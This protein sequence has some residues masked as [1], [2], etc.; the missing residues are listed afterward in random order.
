M[1]PGQSSP[2]SEK[3]RNGNLEWMTSNLHPGSEVWH[4]TPTSYSPSSSQLDFGECLGLSTAP[5]LSIGSEQLNVAAGTWPSNPPPATAPMQWQ[6]EIQESE[7]QTTDDRSSLGAP[8]PSPSY[9]QLLLA[10]SVG[11]TP[12]LRYLISYYIEVITPMIVAFDGP[13]NPFRAHILHLAQDSESLQEAIATLSI[14]NW[15]QRQMGKTMSTERTPASRKACMAHRALTQ[16]DSGRC[17]LSVPELALEEQQHRVRAVKALNAE[18]ADP[19]QRLSD[20]VLATL[21]MLCLFHVCDTGV[22]QFRAQFAG[23]AKLLA[24]RMRTPKRTTDDLKWFIRMF[25]WFDTMTATTNDRESLLRGT[26]LDITSISDGDWGLEDM[27]GCDPGLFRLVAQ[28]GRLNL[29]SQQQTPRGSAPPEMSLPTVPLPPSMTH[30]PQGL[31]AVPSSGF[32]VSGVADAHGLPM[33]SPPRAPDPTPRHASRAFWAEWF[34]LRQKL[35]AWRYFPPG[36]ISM[37]TP[38]TSGPVSAPPPGYISP[39]STPSSSCMVV[40][41]QY[42]EIRHISESFRHAAILCSERLAYP[43]LPSSHSRIQNLVQVTLHHLTAVQCDVYLLW[44]IFVTGSE[45]VLQSHRDVI[46]QRCR[47]ISQDSGFYNNLSCLELLEKIW[48]QNVSTDGHGNWTEPAS[49]LGFE[50]GFRWQQVLRE[51]RADGEC[52]VV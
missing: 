13:T 4:H 43:D 18:L 47:E 52:M 44:P 45:C 3:A 17:G 36:N 23:V 9:S 32:P 25:T 10:K 31:F 28:L 2:A 51:K 40:S 29:L 1:A 35:E 41:Q 33:P 46:G 37:P 42:E 39:P 34:S 38:M 20:S 50:Q 24:L 7:S 22:A 27:A 30:P 19:Y 15:R 16:E 8:C 48:M 11:R 14:S 49:G 12:R 6:P 21:L 5:F 26:C